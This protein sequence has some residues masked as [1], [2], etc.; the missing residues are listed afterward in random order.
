MKIAPAFEAPHA[1]TFLKWV[2]DKKFGD[3]K[4]FEKNPTRRTDPR[5]IIPD[6]QSVIVL[7]MNYF[8]G[9]QTETPNESSQKLEGKIARYAWN[10]D[11]HDL[12]EKKLKQLFTTVEELGGNG[13]YYVDTGPVLERDF[14]NESGLGWSGKS[15]MQIHPELGTW[16]FLATIITNLKLD[17]DPPS[18]DH[19]GKCTACI[20]ACPT[21]AITAP[22]HLD[23]RKCISYLT[24]EHKREIPIEYRK[25]MGDRIYGCDDCL[26]ACPWNKFA[27]QSHEAT[28]QARESVFSK[29]LRDF[30]SL[31]D[32]EFRDLFRKSP[33]KRTKRAGFLRNVC[34]ALGNVGNSKD[35]PALQNT[36]QN[37]EELVSTH[38][39]WAID[40]IKNREKQK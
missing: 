40:E 13:R 17:P 5:N 22:H 2:E 4:W 1:Q 12:I 27:Q 30:L 23:P 14:A 28:F 8:Q 19:C 26:T 32:Q 11:Y 24:I 29:Q 35:L 16:F 37:D 6:A 18:N 36:Y 15:T 9:D 39:K 3:M 38:A 31:N 34:V 33:I 21:E 25:A 10:N 7:A 20:T